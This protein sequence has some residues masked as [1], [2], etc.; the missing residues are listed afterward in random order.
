MWNEELFVEDFFTN[1]PGKNASRLGV[2][3]RK[4]YK[5]HKG[6][7]RTYKEIKERSARK[8]TLHC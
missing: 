8:R 4:E 6:M 2:Q 3:E 7:R 1:L 5:T